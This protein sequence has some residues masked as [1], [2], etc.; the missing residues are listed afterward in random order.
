MKR[1][2]EFKLKYKL[3][4]VISSCYTCKHFDTFHRYENKICRGMSIIS[5]N[6]KFN[7]CDNW[8][9]SNGVNRQN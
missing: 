8:E 7:V 1:E 4:G 9:M 2:Y 6:Y 3:T 5:Y